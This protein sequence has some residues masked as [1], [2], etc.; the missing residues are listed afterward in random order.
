MS[1]IRNANAISQI[2]ALPRIFFL[3]WS[4]NFNE[5]TV[6]GGTCI[7]WNGKVARMTALVV[8]GDVA[9]TFATVPFLRIR[10][11]TG[12]LCHQLFSGLAN[13]LLVHHNGVIMTAMASQIT[14]L[15]IVYSTVYSRRRS[16]KTSKL[17]VTGLGEGDSPVTGEFAAQR[18][19]SN[20]ENVSIWWRHHVVFGAVDEPLASS[21]VVHFRVYVSK[22]QFV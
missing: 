17:R 16:K 3:D 10:P 4:I 9:V 5:I 12:S 6:L 22:R 19:T 7:H 11:R 2:C 21:A 14:S 18:A 1:T 20:A 15:T 13:D 8:I